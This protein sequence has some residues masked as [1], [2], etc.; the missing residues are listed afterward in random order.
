M[1]IHINQ[2]G[3]ATHL[4]KKASYVGDASEFEIC[5]RDGTVIYLGKITDFRYDHAADENVGTIDFSDF[6]ESGTFYITAGGEASD[7]FEITAF[8]YT[9]VKEK[10]I[11]SFY[12]QRCGCEMDKDFA[13]KF[14]R[15]PCHTSI[16]YIV[17][18]NGNKTGD[19]LDTTGGW[20]TAGDYGRYTVATATTLAHL[21]YS[22]ILFP[23]HFE[24]DIKNPMGGNS[25]PDILDECRH[26][27]KWLLKMQRE[28]GGVYHKVSCA[29]FCGDIMP[30]EES[31]D[32]LLCDVSANA[33]ATFCAVTALAANVFYMFD[34]RL[35]K[36]LVCACTRAWDWL[37]RN[38]DAIPFKNPENITTGEYSDDN[39]DDEMFWA[40]AEMYRL[41]GEQRYNSY[42]YLYYRNQILTSF[43]W[44]NVSGFGALAY[45]LNPNT[46]DNDAIAAF[47][48]NRIISEADRICQTADN[49]GYNIAIAPS[50]F[51]WGSNMT[52]LTDA[53]VL[54]VANVIKRNQKYITTALEQLNYVLGKNPMGICYITGVGDKP[55]KN[56][57]HRLSTADGIDEPIPGLLVGGP[58]MY[59]NDPVSKECIPEDTP[60]AKCY[61]D[62]AD[63]YS[64]N[65]TAIYWNSLAVFVTAFFDDEISR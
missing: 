44:C 46:S 29:H 55:C 34:E 24:D 31:D 50:G 54:I 3:Y 52:I 57:H 12:Y 58:N 10:L 39:I 53:A 51:T 21:M 49:S 30:D 17:D 26:G 14:Y 16:S 47:I 62:R 18:E 40:A 2:V 13:G 56:P 23:E 11:D 19:T 28:D 9:K 20:H 43:G 6:T 45:L 36:K 48:E 32:L 41:T 8:P 27:L 65:E 42:I 37:D 4:P 64:I 5:Y 33:T 1:A 25:T 60:P 38:P 7:L 35:S 61:V 59:K 15:S 63:C 22:Y